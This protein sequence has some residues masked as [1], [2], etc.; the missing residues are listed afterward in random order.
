MEC[1]IIVQNENKNVIKCQ[2]SKY[3]QYFT[4]HELSKG[5]K[6]FIFT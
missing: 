3:G 2:N 4:K 6:W 1:D 5:I